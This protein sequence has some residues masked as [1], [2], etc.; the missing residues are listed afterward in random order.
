MKKKI[1]TLSL[2]VA[3]AAT[4][5]IGGT[6]A[7][8]TDTDDKT[9]VM[10]VG[11]VDIVLTETEWEATGKED[12]KDVY[13]GEKL[14]KN[15]VVT[16]NGANPCF[17]RVKVTGL[18][19]LKNAGLSEQE[20]KLRTNYVMD[21]I[22]TNWVKHGD[23]YYYKLILEENGGATTALFDQIAIPTDLVA[24]DADTEYKVEVFAEAVQAQGAKDRWADVQN[25]TV[26]EIAVWFTTCGF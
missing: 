15:P 24:D 17:V 10:T 21:A 25:M 16:N 1:L 20:I 14:A 3:L 5:L 23:Y 18:D 13:P 8:F 26:E 6:L 4:A 22:G 9:N 2:V 12:A 11:N 19:S 7:Y